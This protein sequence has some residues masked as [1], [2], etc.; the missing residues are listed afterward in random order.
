M[1]SSPFMGIILRNHAVGVLVFDEIQE[2]NFTGAHGEL[3]ALFFY[4]Y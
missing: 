1:K 4:V 3:A 2:R